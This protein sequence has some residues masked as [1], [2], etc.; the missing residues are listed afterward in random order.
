MVVVEEEE[1]EA[2]LLAARCS[3]VESTPRNAL[4]TV[5][6]VERSP[7]T[8]LRRSS[9]AGPRAAEVWR[10]LLISNHHSSL[11]PVSLS[12]SALPFSSLIA[13]SSGRATSNT[14]LVMVSTDTPRRLLLRLV[15]RNRDSL[16][17]T[18]AHEA[19]EP[20]IQ[21]RAR[22]LRTNFHLAQLHPRPL[23]NIGLDEGLFVAVRLDEHPLHEVLLLRRQQ[24]AVRAPCLIAAEPPSHCLVA[25]RGVGLPQ[26]R[27]APRL[28]SPALPAA[29]LLRRRTRTR[30]RQ[31]RR[32]W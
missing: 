26:R 7:G 30:R 2:A 16:L 18:A 32:C 25:P 12:V 9:V 29:P 19:L 1:E 20:R 17:I 21:V 6:C 24:H 28:F 3:G 13:A 31:R 23:L 8:S 10:I 15:F 22:Y 27:P 4:R 11:F 14:K 5:V